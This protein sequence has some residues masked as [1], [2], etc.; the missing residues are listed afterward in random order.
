MHTHIH[1]HT[2]TLV[3]TRYCIRIHRCST[4]LM[5]PT[6]PQQCSPSRYLCLLVSGDS[7]DDLRE[8]A[9]SALSRPRAD[10]SSSASSSSLKSDSTAHNTLIPTTWYPSFPDIVGYIYTRCNARACIE[11]N[12]LPYAGPVLS[13]MIT[14]TQHCLGYGA[15]VFEVSPCLNSFFKFLIVPCWVLI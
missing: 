11:S 12:T 14:Y 10:T 7:R 4:L 13:R 2:H 6:P 9:E 5:S 1:T 8:S 15:R 3:Y